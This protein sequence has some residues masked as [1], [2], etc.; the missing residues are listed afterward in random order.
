MVTVVSS[1]SN[2]CG[3]NLPLARLP[4]AL[5]YHR[6]GTEAI[7]ASP[8]QVDITHGS[9]SNDAIFQTN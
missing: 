5:S 9:S 1:E 4:N 7:S 2:I 3:K 8:W 6:G